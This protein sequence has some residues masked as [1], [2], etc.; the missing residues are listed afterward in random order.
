MN[1]VEKIIIDAQARQ[2]ERDQKVRR[3]AQAVSLGLTAVFEAA[4]EVFGIAVVGSIVVAIV[5]ALLVFGSR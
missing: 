2:N 3:N 5:V 4:K 1:E